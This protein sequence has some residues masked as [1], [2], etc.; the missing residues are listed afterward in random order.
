LEYRAGESPT[1][2]QYD[3][4]A[5]Q[6]VVWAERWSWRWPYVQYGHYGIA[7]PIGRKSDPYLFD[8]GSYMGRLYVRSAGAN[9]A[10]L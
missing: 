10:G 4:L 6:I 1:W 3:S 9:I 7:S 8:W 5:E 2:Q